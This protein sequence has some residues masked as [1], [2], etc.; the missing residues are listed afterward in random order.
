MN[1]LI[2]NLLVAGL[3]FSV[4]GTH[5]LCAQEKAKVEQLDK[6]ADSINA[7]AKAPGKLKAAFQ[8]ISSETGVPL[9]Q[10]EHLHKNHPDAGPAGIMLACAMADETKKS[11]GHFLDSKLSGKGWG[12]IA[13][14]NKVSVDKLNQRLDHMATYLASAPEKAE[15]S[16]STKEKK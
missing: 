6:K 12:A 10:V 1:K 13:Q 4:V 16:K 11:A 8:S 2:A 15:T 7:T 14:D 5:E 9:D 3:V